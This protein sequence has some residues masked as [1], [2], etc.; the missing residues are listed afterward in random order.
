MNS[1]LQNNEMTR[2][3]DWI[4]PR[5]WEIAQSM[6]DSGNGFQAK[7][8]SSPSPLKIK[9]IVKNRENPEISSP[10]T[11]Q[12]SMD[13]SNNQ[14]VN[15][16]IPLSSPS[17]LNSSLNEDKQISSNQSIQ[18][19]KE[20]NQ[21]E[22]TVDDHSN[23]SQPLSEMSSPLEK[24]NFSKDSDSTTSSPI[25]LI[26]IKQGN[27]AEIKQHTSSS[28]TNTSPTLANNNM[29]QSMQVNQNQQQQQ[30]QSQTASITLPLPMLSE[31]SLS[32]STTSLG[33]NITLPMQPLQIGSKSRDERN[34]QQPQA[35]SLPAN[36]GQVEASITYTSTCEGSYSNHSTPTPMNDLS[37]QDSVQEKTIAST[38]TETQVNMKMEE[39]T[40][41]DN[42][43]DN[44]QKQVKRE[45]MA[46]TKN[47]NHVETVDKQPRVIGS[48]SHSSPND[49]VSIDSGLESIIP[50]DKTKEQPTEL[51]SKGNKT[52]GHGKQRSVKTEI[53]PSP[54]A[55]SPTNENE[56]EEAAYHN[57]VKSQVRE[58]NS[59]K[60]PSQGADVSDES[61][62]DEGEY[63]HHS[64]R[65]GKEY[66]AVVL[67][68]NKAEKERYLKTEYH[69]EMLWNP[70]KLSHTELDAFISIFP[71][72]L[73]E[74]VFEVISKYDYDLDKAYTE[75]RNCIFRTYT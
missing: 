23:R 15:P 34:K 3:L 30:Q 74:K 14:M 61:S 32:T 43:H 52:E 10:T 49:E 64:A 71:S 19:E 41:H 68:F 72:E 55:D 66:Q 70:D 22:N 25:P 13:T 42:E 69:Q 4:S 46:Y 62:S 60:N 27:K 11:V 12:Q 47:Q 75:V 8:S 51:A 18:R 58:E 44:E 2:T 73:W 16:T 31:L 33:K 26:V 7:P 35:Q 1:N 17:T 20:E 59:M 39:E 24:E 5:E 36:Q 67:R 50:K 65:V 63:P 21:Q 57:S 56:R 53:L 48:L 54:P 9:C 38:Q 40:E 45:Y 37:P 28:S 6:R 29:K